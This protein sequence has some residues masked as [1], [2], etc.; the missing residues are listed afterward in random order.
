MYK[1]GIK[2]KPRWGLV[3]T[4][5]TLVLTLALAACGGANQDPP[6][7]GSD[8]K[9]LVEERCTRCHNLTRVEAARKTSEGWTVTVQ[10][11]VAYGARLDNAE[12]KTVIQYLA[13]TYPK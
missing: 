9:T 11:M 12:Q 7:A 1:K 6:S 10:R 8:G 2:M 5:F 13:E 3:S 4:A